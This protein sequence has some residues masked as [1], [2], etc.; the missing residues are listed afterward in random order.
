MTLL[1][2]L[3]ALLI[4]KAQLAVENLARASLHNAVNHYERGCQPDVG[5]VSAP[6]ACA[7]GS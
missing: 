2:L 5:A 3:R 7:F 4:P 6:R 1:A